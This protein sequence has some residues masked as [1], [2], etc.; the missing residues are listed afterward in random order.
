MIE[1]FTLATSDGESLEARWDSPDDA[2]GVVVFCHPH[3]LQGGSM[4]A[5]LMIAVTG[6]LVERGFSV[7]RFNFRGTGQSTGRHDHGQAELLD[8]AAA[9]QT[10]EETGLRL[11]L[12]G[13]SFGAGVALQWLAG[14]ARALPYSGIAP[15]AARLPDPLPPGPKRIVVGSRDQVVDVDGL[16]EYAVRNQ[17]DLVITPG[18]HFFHGRGKKVGD[19]VAQGLEPV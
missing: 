19:L 8:M 1:R 11:H 15:A 16:L 17:I 12:S 9:V 2:K 3:P 4:M 14:E 10:A 13:W 18:D 6:R 5:P 7:V